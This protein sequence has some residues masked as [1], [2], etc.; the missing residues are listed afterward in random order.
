MAS[1]TQEA[2]LRALERQNTVV[3]EPRAW[4]FRTLYHTFVDHYRK[5]VREQKGKYGAFA[6]GLTGNEAEWEGTIKNPLPALIAIEDVRKA[7]ERLPGE[8]RTVVWLSDAEEFRLQE[9]A[10]ILECPLGT[11][12]SRL[13][14]GRRELRQLLAAYGPEQEK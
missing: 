14:R 9:I 13:A 4:L 1:L 8:F 3:R 5:S 12:A 10:E 7:I 6:L 2:V 11:V